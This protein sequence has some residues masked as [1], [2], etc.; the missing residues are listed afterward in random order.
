MDLKSK[1]VVITGAGSGLGRELARIFA[2]EGSKL[3]LGSQTKDELEAVAKEVGAVS[4]LTDVKHEDQVKNLAKIALNKFG[5]IDV[6]V[7]NAGIRIPLATLEEMDMKRAHEMMEVNLF[8]T[9]YGAKAALV[10]M[11]KQKSGAIVNVLSTSALEGPTGKSGYVA[12]KSAAIGF[13]K[14]LRN[15]TKDVNVFVVGVF[16]GGMRTNFF[17][18]EKP[19]GYETFLDPKI[20]AQRV[21]E[22]LKLDSPLEEVFVKKD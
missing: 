3:V 6:W 10:Q 9:M 4:V 2:K 20:V 21:V 19:K 7:N 1:I 8:G 16:P 22:N 15:E 12:S 11:R 18:E 5:R 13:T 14:S 17:D